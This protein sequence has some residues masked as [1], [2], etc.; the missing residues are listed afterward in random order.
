[1]IQPLTCF[2]RSNSGMSFCHKSNSCSPVTFLLSQ[3]PHFRQPQNLRPFNFNKTPLAPLGT[4]TLAYD[5]PATRTSWAPHA[6]D[7]FYMGPAINH[8]PCL[9]FYIP[10]TRCF[11]FSDTWQLYPTHCQIPVLSEHDKTLLAAGDIFEQLDGT[12]PTTANAKMKHLAAIRQLTAIMLAQPD[13]PPSLVPTAPRMKTA[14][15][16]RVLVAAPPRVATTSNTITSPST[17]RLLPSVH[18]QVTHNNNPLK[19]LSND[20]DDKFDDVLVVAS[21]CSPRTPLQILHDN[22]VPPAVPTTMPQPPMRCPHVIQKPSLPLIPLPSAIPITTTRPTT[23]LS[24]KILPPN[25][26]LRPPPHVI[27]SPHPSTCRV[28]SLPTALPQTLLFVPPVELSHVAH[29]RWPSTNKRA[30]PTAP[31]APPRYNIINPKDDHYNQPIAQSSTPPRRSTP[32][33]YPCM[34]GNNSI[35][36]MHHIMTLKDIKV[37]TN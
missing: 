28:K 34:S 19:I 23:W 7:G 3:S 11:H 31:T 29:D 8:Y 14:T 15:P 16:L 17:I 30:R 4:K 27:P 21:N 5:D 10:S 32:I 33:I 1:V 25:S 18:Q 20:N 12:I 9:C 24:R 13:A 36:A 26:P 6:T 2:A 22:H 35:Q 37:A